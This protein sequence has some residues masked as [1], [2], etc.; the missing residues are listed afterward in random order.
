MKVRKGIL[1]A[2]AMAFSSFAICATSAQE[3]P[4][5]SATDG[6][7]LANLMMFVQLRHAKLWYAANLG[8]W[9]LAAYEVDRLSASFR[10]AAHLRADLPFDDD[11]ASAL[12]AAI[13]AQ[14]AASFEDAFRG[15]T[16]TCNACH[17]AAGFGFIAIRVPARSSPYSNQMFASP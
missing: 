6:A 8:N 17:D 13:A 4:E 7:D 11:V 16:D 12:T 9:P 10:Q 3:Q 2:F 5:R 14:D 15:M 1:F